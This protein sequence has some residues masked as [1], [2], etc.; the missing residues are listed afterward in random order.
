MTTIATNGKTLAADRLMSANGDRVGYIT[1]AHRAPDGSVFGVSG[2]TADCQRFVRW[3]TEEP[4]DKPDLSEDF[5][6]LVLSPEGVVTYYCSKL[7]PVEFGEVS[8][9]GSGADFAIGAMFA[10][11]SPQEAVKIACIRDVYSGGDV[12]V[13]EPVRRVS[14]A[15]RDCGPGSL[16]Q[17]A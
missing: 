2:P 9:I 13:L 6:A 1:K 11:A 16:N 14:P 10:G 15:V 3:L 5:S 8:A 7:E 17:A 4:N 12:T